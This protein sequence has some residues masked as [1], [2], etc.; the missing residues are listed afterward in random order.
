MTLQ[1]PH[2]ILAPYF[3]SQ[4]LVQFS[5]GMSKPSPASM[6]LSRAPR[7][8]LRTFVVFL[9]SKHREKVDQKGRWKGSKRCLLCFFFLFYLLGFV[10]FFFIRCKRQR[11]VFPTRSQLRSTKNNN[12]LFFWFSFYFCG[13]YRQL[14]FG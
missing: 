5:V 2:L 12:F 3:L 8:Y 14:F 4:F 1:I 13:F 11:L 6:G 7:L 9:V 10:G